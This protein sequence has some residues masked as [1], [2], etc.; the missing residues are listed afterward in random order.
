[1]RSSDHVE[2]RPIPCRDEPRCSVLRGHGFWL[3]ACGV[4]SLSRHAEPL[5]LCD[6]WLLLRLETSVELRRIHA[7]NGHA[8][9]HIYLHTILMRRSFASHAGIARRHP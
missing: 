4:S 9:T 2:S 7:P 6:L 3:G 1:M 8:C 5:D